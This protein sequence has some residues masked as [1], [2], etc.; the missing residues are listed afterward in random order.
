MGRKA[1]AGG[2][3]V[4][5]TEEF[6][7]KPAVRRAIPLLIGVAGGTGSGK[8]YSALRLATGLAG[9]ER[10]VV[11]DTENGRAL[12][13]ADEF[14]FDHVELHAPFRPSRYAAAIRAN[15]SYPVVVVDSTSHSWTGAGG[16]LEWHDELERGDARRKML[17]WQEPKAD[18]R[19]FENELLQVRA[20]VI[21]AFRAA[22]KVEMRKNARGEMEVVPKQTIPGRG[23]DGWIPES[24]PRLPYEMTC[25]FLLMADA[26]GV[27]KPIKLPA[28]LRD[29]VPL[30]SPL[31]ETVG[32]ELA[33]WA[34]GSDVPAPKPSIPPTAEPSPGAESAHNLA[35]ALLELWSAIPQ[36][37]RPSLAQLA[38]KIQR[39]T[40]ERSFVGLVATLSQAEAETLFTALSDYQ[41]KLSEGGKT[42]DA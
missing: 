7:A 18:H 40:A 13:Y 5:A 16:V 10:F 38:A 2:G 34:A 42:N 20:H 27:P 4:T 26:P 41:R 30:D 31:S 15:D 12:H 28:A 33:T 17:A 11:I 37:R 21:L 3:L 39:E 8:T 6:V 23:L 14:A 1:Q 9:G 32:T 24:D 36:N 35:A 29:F 25:S 19:V 22:P